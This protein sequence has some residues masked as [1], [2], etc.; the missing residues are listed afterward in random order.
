MAVSVL[1]QSLPL[2]AVGY[3]AA[4]KKREERSWLQNRRLRD[5][6]LMADH[7]KKGVLFEKHPGAPNKQDD[8]LE[9]KHSGSARLAQDSA[10]GKVP[11]DN[12]EASVECDPLSKVTDPGIFGCGMDSHCVA[13]EESEMG[14][15]CVT[16]KQAPS[17]D[18]E[19]QE[20][21]VICLE[22]IESGLGNLTCDCSQFD[23]TGGNFTCTGPFC[24][25]YAC[26]TETFSYSLDF[27]DGSF[28]FD[29]CF[30]GTPFMGLE[31]YC[32]SYSSSPPECEIKVN[33]VV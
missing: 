24:Y 8:A 33:G 21:A 3:R 15:F 12:R 31:S 23:T 4:W 9:K 11:S 6:L 10:L 13:S 32:T 22:E 7:D 19:L 20:S 17:I 26:G 2:L 14:G 28:A 1:A 25:S 27:A 29:N 5:A 16:T 18:R 30:V